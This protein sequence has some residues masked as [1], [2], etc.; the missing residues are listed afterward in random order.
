MFR[1]QKEKREKKSTD[2][3]LYNFLVDDWINV[4][5]S[6]YLAFNWRIIVDVA[7][8]DFAR[9]GR[10]GLAVFGVFNESA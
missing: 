5:R 8:M 10:V 3:R 4:N 9:G 7:T 2:W 1:N 6:Y